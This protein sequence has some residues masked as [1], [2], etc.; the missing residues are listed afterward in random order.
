[1]EKRTPQALGKEFENICSRI[2]QKQGFEEDTEL[3]NWRNPNAA[4]YV[5]VNKQTGTVLVAEIK[6]YSSSWVPRDRFNLVI[7]QLLS[8]RTEF[9]EANL[10]LMI[11][12]PLHET[13]KR[14]A[15]ELGV[16]VWDLPI[17]ADKA[18]VDPDLSAQL[19][20]ILTS[21]G[22]G[23]TGTLGPSAVLPGPEF[24]PEPPAKA[25]KTGSNI[26]ESMRRIP[27]GRDGWKD[28]EN[29][30]GEALVFL[31]GDHFG[32]W[33]TQSE[34]EDGLQRRDFIARLRPKDDFWLSLASD[35]RS[36]YIVFEFKNYENRISQEQIYSTEKYLYATA[37]RSIAIIV[38]RNGADS[39]ALQAAGG[40]LREAGKLI[41]I[42]SLDDLCQMLNARD[43]ADDPT[44]ILY[45][46]LDRLLTRLGR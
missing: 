28:F 21:A 3:R 43:K 15:Q 26:C 22:V 24:R 19:I 44:L 18:S 45:S 9:P 31:F 12:V 32:D 37:L 42:L 27:A 40:A 35:F 30:C 8:R 38:A 1:M 4:D 39:G 23:D 5:G 17:L 14:L 7:R 34:T 36:R 25:P 6:L 46:L 33:S 41:L 16:E 29:Q 11:S 2:L 10:L 20:S 13:W